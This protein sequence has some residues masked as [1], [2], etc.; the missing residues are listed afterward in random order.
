MAKARKTPKSKSYPLKSRNRVFLSFLLLYFI[1][2]GICF[3]ELS[4]KAA[5]WKNLEPGLDIGFL[6]APKKSILGDSLIRVLRADPKFFALK[7]LNSSSSK[8]K[9]RFSVK[10]WV[11]QNSLVAG[12][13]ASMYQKNQISSVSFMK[14]GKHVNSTWVSKDK[15]ILA[16]DPIDKNK[17]PVKIIDRECEDFSSL[18]KQYTSL[19]QSIRM[20]SCK[21]ENVWSPQ[22]KNVEHGGCRNRPPRTGIFHSCAIPLLH[23]RFNQYAF[24]ASHKFKTSHVCRRRGR[25]TIIYQYRQRGARIHW[26]FFLGCPRT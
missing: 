2:E 17:P 15:T 11:N 1:L 8:T 23:P 20:V 6:A 25:C 21:G 3:A 5:I 9:K 12:I 24:A 14:T 22:K 13:N 26:K 7:L 10:K 18:R 19:I 4:K 16:F